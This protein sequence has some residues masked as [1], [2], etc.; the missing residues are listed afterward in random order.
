MGCALEFLLVDGIA[1]G[2]QN[3]CKGIYMG[4]NLTPTI[5]IAV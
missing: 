5:A 1:V 2:D 3:R 4:E